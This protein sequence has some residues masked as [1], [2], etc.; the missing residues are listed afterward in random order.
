MANLERNYT[1]IK[2]AK[3]FKLERLVHE[4]DAKHIHRFWRLT[5]GDRAIGYASTHNE[6]LTAVEAV[7][8]IMENRV[9]EGNVWSSPPA[10]VVW[11]QAPG[12]IKTPDAVFQY[13][14]D[15]KAYLESQPSYSRPNMHMTNIENRKIVGVTD[16]GHAILDKL[17]KAR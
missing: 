8:R 17:E 3:P 13:A 6:T 12:G 16:H 1:E 5:L 10:A 11:Y 15:A 4:Y 9:N 7:T 2:Y 14:R